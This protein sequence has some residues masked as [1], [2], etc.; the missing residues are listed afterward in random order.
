[1][2][3]QP[4]QP[5]QIGRASTNTGNI[6][7]H[8]TPGRAETKPS[9]AR[10]CDALGGTGPRSC[11]W[12]CESCNHRHSQEGSATPAVSQYAR[13]TARSSGPCRSSAP[14]AL[15]RGQERAIPVHPGYVG[16]TGSPELLEP[17]A[18][19]ARVRSQIC[20]PSALRLPP[21]QAA[22]T[23]LPLQRQK[24]FTSKRLPVGSRRGAERGWRWGGSKGVCWRG[25]LRRKRVRGRRKA[26]GGLTGQAAAEGRPEGCWSRSRC[27]KWR[28]RGARRKRVR[29]R[30]RGGRERRGRRARRAK[31][32]R[33]GECEWGRGC[34][35]SSGI[36]AAPMPESPGSALSVRSSVCTSPPK[37]CAAG[38]P[39]GA[40]AGAA[41]KGAAAAPNG[42]A[43][44]R[45]APKAAGGHTQWQRVIAQGSSHKPGVAMGIARGTRNARS[46]PGGRG[47]HERTLKRL[48]AGER[49]SHEP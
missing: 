48:H 23:Q 36:G 45:G 7:C 5:N 30:R 6:C 15:P 20:K 29:C 10:M 27:P 37:G 26:G 44:G 1:M 46:G 17:S 4:H 34:W 32:C 21:G 12:R 42:A 43:A 8:N 33:P 38:A 40:G 3:R 14:L 9:A 24:K 28:R 22:Q 25:S 35:S 13:E 31:S 39:K 2:R 49:I 16:H 41:P 19:K 18:G 11:F 47:R